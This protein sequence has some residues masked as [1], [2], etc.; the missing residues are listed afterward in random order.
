MGTFRTD[1]CW[2][3]IIPSEEREIYSSFFPRDVKGLGPKPALLAIDLYKKV[4]AGGSGPVVEINRKHRGACGDQ[5]WNAI[6]PTVKLFEAARRA[7]IPII[8]TT[9]NPSAVSATNRQRSGEKV[10]DGYEI[11]EEFAPQP[12]DLMIRKE[13]AS[14]F[15][16]TPLFAHLKQRGIES[17]ILCGESTS[18]CLRASVID[19]FSYGF[20]VAVAEE[21]CFDRSVLS[22]KVALFD[23]HH[24]YADVVHV[25]E[26]TSALDGLTGRAAAE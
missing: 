8:Y 20:P 2:D 3:D 7:G 16:G 9:G 24:K 10:G 1:H 5:A 17:L 21:C 6:A 11:K 15:F 13:R 25:E 26:I 12:E 23:L 4:Y 22:H 18:G 14:G 19:A